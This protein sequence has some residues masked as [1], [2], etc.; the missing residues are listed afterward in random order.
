[1]TKLEFILSLHDRLSDLPRDEVN[2]RLNFY[3]EMIEDRIEDGI[4]E[5]EAVQGI[6]TVS[7][8]AEQ[9]RADISGAKVRVAETKPKRRIKV[10]ETVLLALGSPI[11]LSLAIA[12]IA[13]IL[14]LYV[15]L[16]AL[17]ISL[18]AVFASLAACFG[19]GV[20]ACAALSYSGNGLS[21][22][23]MLAAGLV[24]GGLSIFMLYGCIAATKG[25]VL[26]VKKLFIWIRKHFAKK[27]V[28]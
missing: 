12:A 8:I 23:F 1:M 10:W 19:G 13:V 5:E 4:S 20:V 3:A 2:E 22:L 21:S 9:I 6:G 26:M 14:S 15:S 24:C 25:A 17:I 16:W 7:E 27:E 11:W 18:W 28:A